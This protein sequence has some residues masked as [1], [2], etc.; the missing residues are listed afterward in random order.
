MTICCLLGKL[1]CKFSVLSNFC[2]ESE[3]D[4]EG[5]KEENSDTDCS[6]AEDSKSGEVFF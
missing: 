5:E 2:S 1:R 6:D 3:D 4:E